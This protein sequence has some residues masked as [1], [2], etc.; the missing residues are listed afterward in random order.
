MGLRL[1]FLRHRYLPSNYPT[2]PPPC[3]TTTPTRQHYT[4]VTQP[5]VTWP[6]PEIYERAPLTNV[7]GE[8][9]TSAKAWWW[10]RRAPAAGT[11]YLETATSID[12]DDDGDYT[13]GHT[14]L[15]PK[16]NHNITASKL[17]ISDRRTAVFNETMFA[18]ASTTT[19]TASTLPSTSSELALARESDTGVHEVSPA[20]WAARRRTVVSS[21]GNMTLGGA[22]D[23][24]QG[25]CPN[26]VDS[27][28]LDGG[29]SL[30]LRSID[31]ELGD[32]ECTGR[33]GIKH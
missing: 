30:E 25:W 21:S 32:V 26:K 12:Y 13:D 8:S 7:Y 29:A 9:L 18:A 17:I 14:S 2:M 27:L 33:S 10:W 19:E 15:C 23:S 3:H 6:Q 16:V 5:Q 22:T 4:L 31:V 28:H 1:V 11:I 24:S 20:V